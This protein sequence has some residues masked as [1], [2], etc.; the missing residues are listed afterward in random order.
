MTVPQQSL[1]AEHEDPSFLKSK[2]DTKTHQ[3]SLD[4]CIP[5]GLHFQRRLLVM[6]EHFRERQ[7]PVYATLGSWLQ[8]TEMDTGKWKKER[9]LWKYSGELTEC[10]LKLE[11]LEN[12][13]NF[14]DWVAKNTPRPHRRISLIRTPAMAMPSPITPDNHCHLQMIM[15]FHIIPLMFKFWDGKNWFGIPECFH[16]VG[17]SP[18][19]AEDLNAKGERG[20][21]CS[22]WLLRSLAA[23]CVSNAYLTQFKIKG[24]SSQQISGNRIFMLTGSC[25]CGSFPQVV[26]SEKNIHKL[27]LGKARCTGVGGMNEVVVSGP[28]MLLLLSKSN[29]F[30]L[31]K[32]RHCLQ[33]SCQPIKTEFIYQ[34]CCHDQ[35]GP[36]T[37]QAEKMSFIWHGLINMWASNQLLDSLS[38]NFHRLCKVKIHTDLESHK[39]VKIKRRNFISQHYTLLFIQYIPLFKRL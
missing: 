31:E 2:S 24:I 6:V 9:A 14:H 1:S 8:T 38:K 12:R 32:S 37:A 19:W 20:G 21:N 35:H 3:K 16:S 23:V 29:L 18:Q 39:E 5:L 22:H 28:L 15:R 4:G 17:Y 25:S 30:D 10:T 36:N 34:C 27:S 33:N 26:Q 13:R 7:E 11:D